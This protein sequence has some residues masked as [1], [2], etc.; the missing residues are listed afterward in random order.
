MNRILAKTMKENKCFGAAVEFLEKARAAGESPDEA[1]V[2]ARKIMLSVDCKRPNE[3]SALSAQ[4]SF[5]ELASMEEAAE[6]GAL[7]EIQEFKKSLGA[8]KKNQTS[9]VETNS[10]FV[11][12]LWFLL[13]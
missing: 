12:V 13:F 4:K 6:A 11:P 5:Q 9:L 8:R 10:G 2:N 1:K 3:D 7:G